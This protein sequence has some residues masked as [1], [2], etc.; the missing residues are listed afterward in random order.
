M[1]D[2][3]ILDY[4]DILPLPPER[5]EDIIN[6]D[7]P[8]HECVW[9]R[10]EVDVITPK[11]IEQEVTRILKTG[12][13]IF[14]NLQPVWIPPSYYFFLQYF[15]VAGE[16][17]EFRLKRLKHV[18]FK[19]RVRNDVRAIGTYTIKN[20]QDG[21]TTMSMSD[22]LWECAD[23]NMSYGG[24]GI[25]SK[26]RDTVQQSCWRV[27]VAGYNGM[28]QWLKDVLFSDAMS[29]D[30]LATKIKFQKKLEGKKARDI[31]VQYGSS[32]HNTFDS[33]S[34]MRRCI[35]DEVN[36][37]EECSFYDTFLNYQ[38]FIAVGRTRKGLFDIFSSPADT[39]GKHND[40]ALA[41]WRGSDPNN[42]TEFGSTETRVYRYHSNPLEGIEGYYDEFGDADGAAILKWILA[43]RKSVP[44][45]KKQGEIRAFPLN[46]DEMFG[47]FDGGN[48]WDNAQGIKDRVIYL[49]G[50]RY[51]DTKTK[52]PVGVYGNLER[53][54]GYIDGEVEFRP[55]KDQAAGF[56]LKDARWFFSHQPQ[57]NE[58]LKDVFT[59]PAYIENCIGFDPFNNRYELKNKVSQSNAAMVNRKFRDAFNTGVINVPTMT[60]CCRPQHQETNF[61]DVLRSAV[62]LRALVQA[63][64]K[65]DKFA[66]YAEDRGYD[67]WLLNSIDST[68][69]TRK[70]DAPSGGK[71]AFLNEGI[72]LINANTN[73]P[74]HLDDTYW[75]QH[76]W[77]LALLQDYLEFNPL[78]T[79]KNDYTMADIQSLIGC[80]KISKIKRRK[81]SEVN[82]RLLSYLLS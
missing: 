64:N 40:E 66:N 4:A 51:K 50:R 7:K 52:E 20:R 9:K 35:L 36:K 71:N 42:L 46:E 28:P 34:N 16:A 41:F 63:E 21:E 70:G 48:I 38:K 80:I 3:N 32:T 54:D 1:I 59:P 69:D 13:W 33:M 79:H 55:S 39:N 77:H 24:I 72:G 15:P 73:V 67:K 27:M 5:L 10:Q 26:T 37:W 22:A 23:G 25:Q 65:S 57:N 2:F 6:Y 76:H 75:L 29:D 82:S 68:D 8:A 18:Y 62:Y 14:I 53:V 58:P 45:D 12:V 19:I 44:A 47:T 81:H 56:N 31:V 78:D 49:I 74:L 11:Y 60:Y 61:E 43:H 30:K 17:A